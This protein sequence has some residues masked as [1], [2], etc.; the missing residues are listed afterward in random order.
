MGS[1]DTERQERRKATPFCQFLQD[2]W[3]LIGTWNPDDMHTMIA[4]PRLTK[5]LY[6]I[7]K[8]LLGQIPV[9]PTHN[10]TEPMPHAV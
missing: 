9:K 5:C 7:V 2:R 10:N 6:R 3:N 4:D 8:Q 1:H